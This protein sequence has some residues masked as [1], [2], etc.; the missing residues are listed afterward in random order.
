MSREFVEELYICFPRSIVWWLRVFAIKSGLLSRSSVD[1]SQ[2]VDDMPVF[3]INLDRRSDRRRSIQS[4]LVRLGIHNSHR[5][6]A[7]PHTNGAL[8]CARSHLR[9]AERAI[10]HPLTAMVVEDDLKFVADRSE[11]LDV[12]TDFLRDDRLDVLCLAHRSRRSLPWSSKLKISNDIQTTA[13]YVVKDRAWVSL[14]Q[15]FRLSVEELSNGRS[16]WRSAVDIKWKK[17]QSFNLLFAIPRRRLALQGDSWSDISN[18][19]VAPRT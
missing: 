14:E 2:S 7:T 3:F 17:D 8:G 19:W 12:L 11:I 16:V 4:E 15:T 1:K 10:V 5:I 6:V 18:A 13:A 9:L